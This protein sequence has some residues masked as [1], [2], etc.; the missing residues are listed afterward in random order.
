MTSQRPDVNS[1]RRQEESSKTEK[2][3]TINNFNAKIGVAYV[4]NHHINIRQYHLQ[5]DSSE[6]MET[7]QRKNRLHLRKQE[8]VA[9][10]IDDGI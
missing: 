1:T 3:G 10:N 2:T 4:A 6:S 7:R 8:S 5:P 9:P